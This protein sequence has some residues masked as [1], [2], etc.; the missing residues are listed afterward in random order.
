MDILRHMTV[1]ADLVVN[2]A[3]DDE[4]ENE[5]EEKETKEDSE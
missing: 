4:A 3:A 1:T 5:H 2:K